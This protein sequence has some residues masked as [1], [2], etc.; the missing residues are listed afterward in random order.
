MARLYRLAQRRA[1]VTEALDRLGL[2]ARSGQLA[3][4]LSGG[5]KQ[6][7]A[8]AYRAAQADL[9]LL[10]EPTAGVDP[11]RGGNLGSI[12]SPK[13]HDMVSTHYMDEAERCRRIAYLA[14]GKL[15]AVGSVA[16][17]CT[18]RA[19]PHGMSWAGAAHRRLAR[20][21]AGRPGVEMV[22]PSAPPCM[23]AGQ[24][25]QRWKR[26]H[27]SRRGDAALERV[28]TVAGGRLHSLMAGA[29]A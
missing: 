26:S 1:V 9:L 17:W 16:G 2:A 19:W 28:G 8:L 18:A 3:G 29:Q 7:L 15:L 23:S 5:W 14:Y 25:R 22:A 12:C 24:T 13:R 21:L 20:D 4:T 6:R 10:D 27:P 11:K